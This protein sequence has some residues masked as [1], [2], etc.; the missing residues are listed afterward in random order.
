MDK[1]SPKH[2]V[3][4]MYVIREVLNKLEFSLG[5]NIKFSHLAKELGQWKLIPTEILNL[6]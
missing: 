5:I 3:L 6:Y 4:D 2:L 1:K